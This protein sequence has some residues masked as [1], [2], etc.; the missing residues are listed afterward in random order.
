MTVA[1]HR[2]LLVILDL[3]LL[4]AIMVRL[5][6][7]LALVAVL[8]LLVTAASQAPLLNVEVTG[9]ATAA[10]SELVV[11]CLRHALVVRQIDAAECLAV[12]A[13]LAG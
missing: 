10:T 8:V 11:V 9:A 7:L 6:A 5:T 4:R 1:I 2:L 12:V 3:L 13:P